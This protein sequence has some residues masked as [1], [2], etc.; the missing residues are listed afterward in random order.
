MENQF[1]ILLAIFI[2]S[3]IGYFIF[4]KIRENQKR[5]NASSAKENEERIKKQ[6]KKNTE[7]IAKIIEGHYIEILAPE[8]IK[9]INAFDKWQITKFNLLK[10]ATKSQKKVFFDLGD[11]DP[12]KK[13]QGQYK[14]LGEYSQ[15]APKGVFTLV[16]ENCFTE[17]FP[18]THDMDDFRRHQLVSMLMAL[19]VIQKGK[20]IGYYI[21][22]KKHFVNHD[23]VQ[24][25]IV[26]DLYKLIRPIQVMDQIA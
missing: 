3:T 22:E 10:N 9:Y 19:E 13:L 16:M 7:F 11:R 6:N 15:E 2:S 5:L 1:Y 8:R 25:I 26:I 20:S 4:I 23:M 14:F 24:A 21:H 12:N 17:P 18:S